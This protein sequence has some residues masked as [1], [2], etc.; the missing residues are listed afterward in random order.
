MLNDRIF[1]IREAVKSVTRILSGRDIEVTQRGSQAYVEHHGN[2]EVRRVNIPYIPDNASDDLL[3]A[4]QGFLDHEVGHLLFSDFDL[5][6]K[7]SQEGFG[8]EHN[9]LED[10]FVERCMQKRFRGS[11]YNLDNVRDFFLRKFISPKL[12]E[13]IQNN[14][15]EAIEG[16]LFVPAVRAWSGQRDVQRFMEDKWEH[17][18]R[19]VKI[20]G[21]DI[22]ERIGHIAS[23]QDSYEIAKEMHRRLKDSAATPPPPPSNPTGSGDEEMS[24]DNNSPDDD[25]EETQGSASGQDEDQDEGD[26]EQEGGSGGDN[27]DSDE[28]GDEEESEG[29]SSDEGE[30]DGDEEESGQDDEPGS[31]NEDTTP[32]NDGIDSDGASSDES[33]SDDSDGDD[34]DQLVMTNTDKEMNTDDNDYHFSLEDWENAVND[35]DMGVSAAISEEAEEIGKSATYRA[36]TTDE[37]VVEIW[38]PKY[39]ERG[40]V[41]LMEDTVD[42]MLGVMEKEL[43]RLIKAQSMIRWAGGKRKGSLNS[44]S[45][46]KLAIGKQHPELM[47]MR[48]FRQKEQKI[49]NDV[50]VQLVVDCSG[51]MAG[52]KMLTAAQ[53]AYALA[54]VLERIDVPHEVIGFTTKPFTEEVHREFFEAQEKGNLFSR[55]EAIYLPIFKTFDE[56]FTPEVKYRFADYPENG[57]LWNNVDGE[58][59]ELCYRRLQSRRENGKLM[60]VLSDGAPAAM[61][62][63]YDIREYTRRV[64]RDI[65][66]TDTNI[67]GIGI[68]SR[69]VEDYYTDNLVLNK[70]EDLPSAVMGKLKTILLASLKGK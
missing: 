44:R 70:V 55:G 45:L 67:I 14:D 46:S 13:A 38:K 49:T 43:E 65:E 4:I 37:D 57:H 10:P 12:A 50:A 48:V 17:L 56:R 39:P 23:T 53:A 21:D 19:F 9:I 58:S 7:S 52:F 63:S 6:M 33:D 27:S 25:E 42:H 64:I 36:F 35:F 30:E 41:G 15:K 28:D 18:E 20:V 22:I 66:K 26:E 62:S 69:A 31:E 8:Q 3:N 51:S 60:I 54:S 11:E 24:P 2:G 61:G 29:G 47:D 40:Q 32:S 68:L 59:I 16:I 34:D 1:L 5:L